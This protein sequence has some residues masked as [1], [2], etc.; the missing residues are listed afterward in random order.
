MKR[1][2]GNS[3]S[4][5]R[6][7]LALCLTLLLVIPVSA[8][9]QQKIIRTGHLWS[10]VI[11]TG[12]KGLIE[13]ENLSWAPNDWNIQGPSM[14]NGTA[15]TGSGMWMA[16][17]NWTDP[18]GNVIPK[19]V[20]LPVP[21]SDYE[22]TVTTVVNP[23]QS[24]LRWD[25]P[26]NYTIQQEAQDNQ[27]D[28]WGD[29][30]PGQ[31]IGTSDQVLKVTNMT[32]MGVQVERKI[33][34]WA[35]QY[36]DDYIVCEVILTNTS[37]QTLND[38]YLNIHENNFQIDG[39]EGDDP[40][41]NI[42]NIWEY[43]WDHYYGSRQSDSL[44]IYYMYMADD[45]SLSGD[46]M[47]TPVYNQDGRLYQQEIHF[48]GILHASQAPFT[49]DVSNS[50]D[51]PSQPSVSLVLNNPD[52]DIQD[53]VVGGN[54]ANRPKTY[55]LI[56]GNSG[57]PVQQAFT[58]ADGAYPNTTH[59]IPNDERGLSNWD[60]SIPTISA[61]KP[62]TKRHVS[63]GPY[64][65]DP[66]EKL[67]FVWVSGFAGLSLKK[68]KEVGEKWLAGTLEEPP[69]LPDAQTGYFPS[70][71]AFPGD[72]TEMDKTKDRWLS[73]G[74]DSVHQAV[75]RAK[76][77]FEND[78][79]AIQAP[80][81]PHMQIY[82]S[83]EGMRIQFAAPEAES[84]SNFFGYRVM[85]RS[86]NQDT[87]FYKEIHRVAADTAT[88]ETVRMGS[89][90]FNGYKWVDTNAKPGASYY[91]YVQSGVEVTS[92]Q[93]ANASHLTAGEIIWSGRVF[94]TSRLPV[95]TKRA[96][97]SSLDSIRIAPNPYYISDPKLQTYGL[98]NPD[99]PRLLMFFNLP[100]EV[101]IKIFT[102]AGDLVKRIN[103]T[104]TP[105]SENVTASSGFERWN[106]LTDN[107]Q[108]ISS[109]VYIA[110]FETPSGQS[111][112]QKFIVVR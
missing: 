60:Q 55:D 23:L 104:E 25:L 66:G 53:E 79:Q 85:R 94:G 7:A 44:R 51:D 41:I 9:G 19:A 28:N 98:S 70:N 10:G 97:G 14:E 3:T 91:Y 37:D 48:Y 111:S 80:Q 31:M 87:T 29:P 26:L 107:Q 34:G 16:A 2:Y 12:G 76:W 15:Q 102:E 101:T 90:T 65:F 5:L 21:S 88:K 84:R 43:T 32:P 106:M 82:G 69:N 62:F 112:Y 67:R 27:V 45:A 1:Q 42:Q 105:I 56:A 86:G 73:T 58:Q 59:Q 57:S 13:Y 20:T 95:E 109:G 35:Q 72:A 103:H 54:N 24:Y 22:G 18:L 47:G 96:V 46:Q 74:I 64:Q 39:V 75:S 38:Y 89:S 33:Y 77:N 63:F 93:A 100:P 17:T 4:L 30:N 52:A 61:A 6:N 11:E 36:H 110:V 40:G 50:V 99:D 68:A 78:W 71:F 49:G 8:M 81:P 92:A 108:A 83:G